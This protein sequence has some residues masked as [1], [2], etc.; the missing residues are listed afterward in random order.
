MKNK[1]SSNLNAENVAKAKSDFKLLGVSLVHF[2]AQ[3][4]FQ[5]SLT[6]CIYFLNV[7]Y[8]NWILVMGLSLV[9]EYLTYTARDGGFIFSYFQKSKKKTWIQNMY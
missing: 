4:P 3:K 9:V 2:Y 7:G 6:V 5:T 8:K 1:K